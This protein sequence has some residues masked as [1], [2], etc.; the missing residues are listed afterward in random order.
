[1]HAPTFGYPGD[2]YPRFPWIASLEARGAWLIASDKL[3]SAP[4]N[5]VREILLWGEGKNGPITKF[6]AGLGNV[7]LLDQIRSVI[8]AIE[9]P[10][11]A[12][13]QAL[14]IP[15][16]GLTYASKLLRFLCPEKHASLDNRIREALFA[17]GLLEKLYDSNRTSMVRGYVA[18]Q[19]L[20]LDLKEELEVAGYPR[21]A[22][23]LAQS[24]S[25][26][27]WRV[28]DIEMALFAWADKRIRKQS[29]DNLDI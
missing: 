22:S 10:E 12:I 18:F 25:Q 2:S 15:G 29:A 28:A 16:C 21:P 6:E 7:S 5:Y 8:A 26:T 20:L 24:Q 9:D 14:Q 27:G 19:A 17:E 13:S 4:T 23:R 1:M 3:T 11:L